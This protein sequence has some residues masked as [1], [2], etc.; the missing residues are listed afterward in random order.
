MGGVTLNTAIATSD[1]RRIPVIVPSRYYQSY[2]VGENSFGSFPASAM[3]DF[4]ARQ[5]F[6]GIDL[7]I[8][9]LDIFDDS[10]KSVY[11]SLKRR[12]DALGLTI[13]VCH[14][15]FY[16][17]DPEDAAAMKR[18]SASV[19]KALDIAGA[20]GIPCAVIHPIVRHSSRCCRDR[21]IK[22]NMDFLTPICRR[23]GE[24]GVSVAV[25]NMAGIPYKSAV[26]DEVFGTTAKD[27]VLL[28]DALGIGVCWDTGHAN[29]TGLCQSAE[30]SV[31]GKRLSVLH[32]HGNDG[33]KDAHLLPCN[34]RSTMDVDDLVRGLRSV[35]FTEHRGIYLDF[36]VKTSSL[37]ADASVREDF[38]RLTM[39][40]AK[41]FA[42]KL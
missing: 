37:P 32:L 26:G 10:V 3:V 13:P 20:M 38:A 40:S 6:D 19:E 31:I 42:R 28:A 16:M 22:K 34:P 2:L 1:G 4:L 30:L 5:G 7:S 25:E 11:L 29:I 17:P 35:G 8:D 24:L 21:W 27:V 15:P 23:A 33:K 39:K 41:W 14:L 9:S 36:E 12:A 18:Y